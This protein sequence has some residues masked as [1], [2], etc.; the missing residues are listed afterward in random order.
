VIFLTS[1]EG[2]LSRLI[3]TADETFSASYGGE[4]TH[5]R[6]D[7][8]PARQRVLFA[9]RD[10]VLAGDWMMR[11]TPSL[12][13]GLREQPAVCEPRLIEYDLPLLFAEAARLAA[14]SG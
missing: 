2:P 10:Q 1:R 12:P 9:S 6:E 11:R 7:T 3:E 5:P 8:Y 14:S 13:A 4:H